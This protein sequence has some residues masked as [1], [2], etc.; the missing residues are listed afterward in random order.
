MNAFNL[1]YPMFAMVL[2]TATVLG[3]LF[4]SR[5]RAVREQKVTTRFFRIYQGETEPEISAQAA[6]HFTNLFEAPTLF[7]AACLAAM[8]TRQTGLTVV[9]LAWGYVAAR[10]AH[11]YIHLGSNRLKHRIRAYF[12]GWLVLMAMWIVIVAGVASAS[13]SS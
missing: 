5:V 6:R 4:R 13:V 2:L 11:A 9:V 10:L 3:I 12:S 1:I 8:V 7:Y